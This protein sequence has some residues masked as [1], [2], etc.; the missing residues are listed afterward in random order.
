[1]AN[2]EFTKEKIDAV[3]A[4]VMA[5]MDGLLKNEGALAKGAVEDAPVEESEGSGEP[6]AP[7]PAGPPDEGSAPPMDAAP[8][9]SAPPEASA[10]MDAAPEGSAPMG[11]EQGEIAPAPTVEALQA[12]YAK[13]DPEAL[14]MHYLACKAQLMASMGQDQGQGAPPEASAPMAPPPAAPPGAAPMAMGEMKAKQLAASSGNGGKLGK[15]E[16]QL[17]IENLEKQLRGQGDEMLKLAA[18]MTKLSTPIRKSIKG[19]SD[20]QYIARS[21]DAPKAS[22][23]ASMSE[24]EIKAKLCEKVREGKLT[25]SEKDLVGKYTVGAVNFSEIEHLLAH[26]AK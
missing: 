21:E 19:V 20:L 2:I 18:V 14:K 9:G 6:A 5:E 17:K 11:E 26:P 10:P 12:E 4:E 8:E 25:K 3:F 16:D 22:P 13:L 7:A 24:K 23:A 1:M 15:S